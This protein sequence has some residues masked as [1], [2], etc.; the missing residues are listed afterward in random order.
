MGNFKRSILTTVILFAASLCFAKQITLQIVQHDESTDSVLEASMV[1][2]DELLNEFFNCGFIVTNTPASVSDS[3]VQD[4]KLFTD[5]IGD[6]YEGSSE[7]FVQIKLYYNLAQRTKGSDLVKV[8]WTLASALT[9]LKIEEKS[10]KNNS[11]DIKDLKLMTANL[12]KEITK[13][14]KA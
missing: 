12:V 14:I 8:D 11:S 4:S 13:A 10:M 2:E 9:G 7:Y 6:A 5:G 3:I 1:V